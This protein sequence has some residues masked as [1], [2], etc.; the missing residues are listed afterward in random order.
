[1]VAE[2][3][4][5]YKR[6]VAPLGQFDTLFPTVTDDNIVGALEDGFSDGRLLGLFTRYSL[7]LYFHEIVPDL[8]ADMQ[9]LVVVLA[10][11][12]GLR[13]GIANAN[14]R[15]LYEAGPVKY[16][17]EKAASV[18]TGLLTD[19]QNRLKLLLDQL[20]ADD[21]VESY[22]IDRYCGAVMSGIYT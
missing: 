12:Q 15:S 8:D 3:I 11:I 17:V 10:G 16:E 21:A 1:M 2:L 20:G 9:R 13:V 18:L 7:D 19:A 22:V 14:T 4:P 6:E 5:A